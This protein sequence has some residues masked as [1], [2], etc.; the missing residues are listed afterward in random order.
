[1][2]LEL[3]QDLLNTTD[4]HQVAE[5]VISKYHVKVVEEFDMPDYKAIAILA[6]PNNAIVND[7]IFV[8]YE[9]T[10]AGQHQG[11]GELDTTA[12]TRSSG[13]SGIQ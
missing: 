3:R 2:I 6:E 8:K 4:I 11:A 10:L 13:G 12:W 1:M 5:D 7:P 9:S